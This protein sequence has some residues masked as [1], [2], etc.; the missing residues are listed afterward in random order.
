MIIV[1]NF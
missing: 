1:P